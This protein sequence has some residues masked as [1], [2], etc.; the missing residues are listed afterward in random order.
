MRG[1]NRALLSAG[2]PE[3]PE[4]KRKQTVYERGTCCL[5][6][7][8]PRCRPPVLPGRLLFPSDDGW[9]RGAI[10][11]PVLQ[12]RY[13]HNTGLPPVTSDTARPGSGPP[14]SPSPSDPARSQPHSSL[15]RTGGPH[16]HGD[17][18]GADTGSAPG[19]PEVM[20]PRAEHAQHPQTTATSPLALSWTWCLGKEWGCG[21]AEPWW[22]QPVGRGGDCSAGGTG[23]HPAHGD[24]GWKRGDPLPARVLSSTKPAASSRDPNLLGFEVTRGAGKGKPRAVR[25][26]LETR[27]CRGG[28][29]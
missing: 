10:Q 24:E 17:A 28:T 14:G 25:L 27:S 19:A 6:L 15:C 16:G 13:L 18:L 4:T 8:A 7:R 2:R 11:A 9:T 12:Q 23:T 20:S 29:G 3:T 5:C 22:V 26:L 1:Q 21:R